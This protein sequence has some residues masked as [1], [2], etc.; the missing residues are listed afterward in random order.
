[1][2]YVIFCIYIFL[3]EKKKSKHRSLLNPRISVSE[4]IILNRISDE[5]QIPEVLKY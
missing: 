1:M 4:Q 3:L 5:L 2:S